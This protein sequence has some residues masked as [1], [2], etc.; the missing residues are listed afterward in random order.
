MFVAIWHPENLEKAMDGNFH[1]IHI[2]KRKILGLGKLL[3]ILGY[4]Q[5]IPSN[6]MLEAIN[7]IKNELNSI[8]ESREMENASS[9]REYKLIG[10]AEGTKQLALHRLQAVWEVY[11]E[12]GIV[13]PPD[14]NA[15][16]S[17]ISDKEKISD[18]D[19][20]TLNILENKIRSAATNVVK[21]QLEA[22]IKQSIDLEHSSDLEKIKRVNIL[23]QAKQSIA[24]IESSFG[25][26]SI[27]EFITS[28]ALIEAI[29]V[30]KQ[31][32]VT[33]EYDWSSVAQI[34]RNGMQNGERIKPYANKQLS[35][36]NALYTY[37]I[38]LQNT[39][40]NSETNVSELI[41]K[42]GLR[43]LIDTELGQ[44]L[45]SMNLLQD[46]DPKNKLNP[47]NL[48]NAI[49][50]AQKKISS[51]R[52]RRLAK[53]LE[54]NI[55]N[56]VSDQLHDHISGKL[57]SL[58]SEKLDRLLKEKIK[59]RWTNKNIAKWGEEIMNEFNYEK[60]IQGNCSLTQANH[61]MTIEDTIRDVFLPE[62]N[63][64]WN[65]MVQNVFEN[66]MPFN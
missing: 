31:K 41:E 27:E 5:H 40:L 29:S 63:I 14:L 64:I 10:E 52:Q 2:L 53:M 55:N 56:I 54:I 23:L 22:E 28:N 6:S 17:R 13:L 12:N 51:L 46:E 43:C 30:L 60:E 37:V 39:Q 33:G 3:E 8:I 61:R 66:T 50:E 9:Q 62:Y 58:A 24:G 49:Q 16:Y 59:L 7:K 26:T 4:L 35:N 25:L 1:D 19:V 42:N 45:T 15:E 11:E 44:L 57:Y 21:N 47:K 36:L 20:G 34:F 65:E 18:V 38:S 32:D 48:L